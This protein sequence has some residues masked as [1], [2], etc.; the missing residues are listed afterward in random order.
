M[1]KRINYILNLLI[2]TLVFTSCEV[3]RTE[4]IF[5]DPPAIR[6]EKEIS[7]LRTL[8][9]SQEQGFSGI[10]F[11]NNDVVGGVNFHMNFTEDLRVK[12]TSDFKSTTSLTDTRYEIVTGTTAAELVFT[13]GSRHITDLIQDGAAGFDTF[14]G[15]NSFQYVGEDNGVI[16]FREVRSGGI[17]V[18]SPSGFTDFDTES[19]N[20]ANITY[21]NRMS[22]TDVDC[23]NSSV[24]DNLVLSIGS[25]SDAVTYVLNYNPDNI[26]FDAET[27]DSE[28]VSSRQG[29]GAAFTL[30]DRAPAI[31]ISP[32]L[33]VQGNSFEEFILDTSS[34]QYIATVNGITATISQTSL[35]SPTGEDIFDLPSLAYFYDTADGTNPLL[36][37]CFQELVIDQINTNL[38]NRFGP[39]VL[40]F[41]FYALFLDFSGNC[42]QLAIF[43]QDADGNNFRANYC[44]VAS[45]NNNTLFLNYAGPFSG[46]N[47]AFFEADVAPLIDFFGSSQGLL[48]TNEGPFRGSIN[49]YRD[50]SG[51]FTSLENESLRCYGLF[52]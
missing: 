21:A 12:M 35:S 13:T 44:H 32:A 28:G 25:G 1:K 5:D 47:D 18:I 30:I 26:F 14:F 6:I 10:Y 45:V 3:D 4:A 8:L 36:S 43:L 42:S 40:R 46:F 50:P 39:G 7:E 23:S 41:A 2:V 48:Y 51:A 22:F 31:S 27:T 17:F 38:E 15:S 9:L 20:T 29:L 34:S 33:E 19:V 11:P 16:T 52:F 24:Y 49:S 37:P